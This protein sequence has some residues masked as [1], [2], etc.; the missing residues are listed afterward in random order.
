MWMVVV[1]K[2]I[3]EIHEF[4]NDEVAANAYYAGLI[5]YYKNNGDEQ[6]VEVFLT[7]V[8]HSTLLQSQT[9]I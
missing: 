5:E 8:E 9:N 2:E 1:N 6:Q 7:K 4:G 3:P